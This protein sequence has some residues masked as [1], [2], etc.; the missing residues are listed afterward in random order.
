MS[1]ISNITAYD[2]ASTPTSHTLVAQEVESKDSSRIAKYQELVAGL[3]ND[4][5]VRASITKTTLS[6]RVVKTETK[7]V[8]PVMEAILNQNAAGY[9]AAPK[10]AYE[11]T[12]IITTFAHPRS[13]VTSRRLARQLALNIAGSISTSVTPVVTGPVPEVIDQLVS[14]T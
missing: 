1:N 5:Q 8:V 2:G 12:V 3:P 13:S 11:D 10:V 6:S 4:A 9:T 7:V 14:P